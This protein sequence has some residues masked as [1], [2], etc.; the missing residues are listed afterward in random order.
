MADG[1]IIAKCKAVYGAFLKKSDYDSLIQRTSVSAIT[2]YLKTVPHYRKAFAETDEATIHRGQMEQILNEHIFRIYARIRKF[3]T[4]KK[5]GILDFYIKKCEAEQLIKLITAIASDNRQSFFLGLPAYLMDYL[6][7]DPVEALN[8]ANFKELAK[9]LS[10]VRMYKP[11]IPYL[12]ADNPDINKCIIVVNSCYLG[13]AFGAIDRDVKKSKRES[14][15]QFFLRKI[16]M[17][18]V[19]LCYRLKKYFD[20]DE[21]RIKE[22]MLPFHY[23]VRP[24]DIDD[25]L[26]MQ[27]PTDA[28]IKLLS[29]R[30][31]TGRISVDESFP[32]LAA[33]RSHYEFFR[34]R[35]S[36]TCDEKEA[37]FS[38]VVLMET[39]RMNLQK[40]IEGVRYGEQPSEIEKLVII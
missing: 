34:H 2:A 5:N 20:E 26:R 37:L 21:E 39:E 13:W 7:F 30:C 22:L 38:L 10:D 14:L 17:D 35:L 11:L 3:G 4:A 9:I 40:I 15:K 36:L 12:E 27:N 6:S 24:S 1:A 28:L 29:E 8:S 23:R 31:V 25:A 19:L 16:D 33:M 18:N 32:E